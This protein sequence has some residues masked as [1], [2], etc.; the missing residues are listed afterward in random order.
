MAEAILKRSNRQAQSRDLLNQP[1]PTGVQR[2]EVALA[3]VTGGLVALSFYFAGQ[4]LFL[5]LTAGVALLASSV[6]LSASA[7]TRKLAKRLE[8][9]EAT[10][11][12]RTDAP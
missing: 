1:P 8:A 3:M 10:L 5:A 2:G 9:L 12:Q 4:G 6:A 7:Q 11:L